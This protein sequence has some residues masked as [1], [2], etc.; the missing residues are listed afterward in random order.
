MKFGRQIKSL[1]KFSN[2]Q[3]KMY[4]F[5]AKKIGKYGVGIGD[6]MTKAG[7]ATG[8]AQLM[9]AG[10]LVGEGSGIVGDSGNLV[11]KVRTIRTGDDVASAVEDGIVLAAKGAEFGGKV[12]MLV[13]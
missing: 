11:E 8:N 13:G 3:A 2:K 6:S 5:G 7:A 1:S 4:S 12:S 10:Q 9:M